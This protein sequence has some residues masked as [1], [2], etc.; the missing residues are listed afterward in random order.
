LCLEEASKHKKEYKKIF[1]INEKSDNEENEEEL[2]S[3]ADL[4]QQQ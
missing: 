3:Q 1:T 4:L 2:F